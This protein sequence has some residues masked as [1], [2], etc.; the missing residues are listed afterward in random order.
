[1]MP[2]TS[3]TIADPW[4]ADQPGTD[5]TSFW[6]GVVATILG[7]FLPHEGSLDPSEFRAQIS[8]LL[9]DAAVTPKGFS[10]IVSVPSAYPNQG[11]VDVVNVD[12]PLGLYDIASEDM[13]AVRDYVSAF[14]HLKERLAW[15]PGAVA[16]LWP[17]TPRQPLRLAIS[18]DPESGDPDLL[19]IGAVAE[20]TPAENAEGIA[21][22]YDLLYDTF[23][24]WPDGIGFAILIVN[25]DEDL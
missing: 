10:G 8:A 14:G 16:R 4:P 23:G 1:M 11:V 9:R 2:P 13:V 20:T 3:L 15:L 6:R 5:P 7:A 12:D 17:Q 25:P 18:N 21:R 22:L 19:V 24:P